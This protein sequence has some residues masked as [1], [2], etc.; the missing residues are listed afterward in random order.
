MHFFPLP[1]ILSA[2][3][4]SSPGLPPVLKRAH[5]PLAAPSHSVAQQAT[6]FPSTPSPVSPA[7][8]T[9]ASVNQHN[10]MLVVRHHSLVH[11]STSGQKIQ[12]GCLRQ[13]FIYLSFP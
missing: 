7:S 6:S 3:L 10:G 1:T 9:S 12:Q 4:S 13:W 11:Q 5:R 8:P 2:N